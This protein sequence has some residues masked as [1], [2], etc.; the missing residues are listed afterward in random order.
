MNIFNKISRILDNNVFNKENEWNNIY[1]NK[2]QNK[3]IPDS[4]EISGKF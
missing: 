1:N 3:F 4:F 2:S